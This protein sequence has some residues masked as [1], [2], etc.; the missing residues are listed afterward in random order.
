MQGSSW[1]ML[2]LVALLWGVTNPLMKRGSSGI[3]SERADKPKSR[4]V[5]V[6]LCA[7]LLDLFTRPLY[8]LSFAVNMIGSVLFILSLST[9]GTPYCA[10][11]MRTLSAPNCAADISLSTPL[12]NSLTFLVTTVTSRLLGEQALNG[13]T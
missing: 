4:Y 12:T 2:V 1:L 8:L 6:R 9:L 13:C 11:P 3:A 7:D 10:L 5:L